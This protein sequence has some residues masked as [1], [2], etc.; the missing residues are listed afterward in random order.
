[1]YHQCEFS[2]DSAR[3]N[4]QYCNDPE[5]IPP[6]IYT[7]HARKRELERAGSGKMVHRVIVHNRVITVLPDSVEQRCKRNRIEEKKQRIKLNK[8][9]QYQADRQRE[10]MERY[11]EY[12]NKPI[13]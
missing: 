7:R 8:Q 5:F 6:P 3:L 4:S 11:C 12:I 1:M 13:H 2:D 10:K 9:K